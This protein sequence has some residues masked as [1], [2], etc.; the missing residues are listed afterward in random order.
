MLVY[1]FNKIEISLILVF[2]F[3]IRDFID[4]VPVYL[5]MNFYFET[6][7]NLQI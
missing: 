3:M 2:Y 6:G 7:L 5:M 1:K 4:S